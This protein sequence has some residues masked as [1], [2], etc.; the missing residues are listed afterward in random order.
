MMPCVLWV[1]DVA[2]QI[3]TRL[4]DCRTDG[5]PD[6]A[7]SPDGT[8]LLYVGDLGVMTIGVDGSAPMVVGSV[9]SGRAGDLS[10]S[11]DGTRISFA[12]DRRL[13]VTSLDEWNPVPVAT[14]IDFAWSPDWSRVAYLRDDVTRKSS[15]DPFVLQVFTA[16]PDGTGSQ[17]VTEQPGCCL[18]A[19]PSLAWSPDGRTIVV[20]GVRIQLADVE[21]GQVRFIKQRDLIPGAPPVWRPVSES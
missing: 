11:P 15:G 10:W 4:A 2:S 6:L 16:L 21:S 1:E 9:A 18:G 5:G 14:G 8:R 12:T 7:W 13:Y 17:L 20:T 3:A 19:R